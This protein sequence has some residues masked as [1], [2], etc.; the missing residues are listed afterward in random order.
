MLAKIANLAVLKNL[1]G[2][3]RTLTKPVNVNALRCYAT[4]SV[5]SR[6]WNQLNSLPKPVV[7]KNCLVPR[8]PQLRGVIGSSLVQLR[9]QSTH[10]DH[11]NLWK[12]ERVVSALFL[13]LLPL[14][15]MLENPILDSVLAVASVIHVHWGLEAIIIDYARPLVVGPVVPKILM[16]ALYLTSALTLAGLMVLIYNG[17][18]LCKVIKQGWAIGKDK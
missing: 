7:S 9:N 13:P 5:S 6:C 2:L 12:L 15:F 11:V 18:G 8:S 4:G 1:T 17:P 16:A 14:A 3:S 10:G